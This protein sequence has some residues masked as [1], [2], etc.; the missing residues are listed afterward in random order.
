MWLF[1]E[2]GT[3]QVCLGLCLGPKPTKEQQ[4]WLGI[5]LDHRVRV[6]GELESISAPIQVCCALKK[7]KVQTESLWLLD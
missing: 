7:K 2:K 4:P 3:W 1:W 5:C 6:P